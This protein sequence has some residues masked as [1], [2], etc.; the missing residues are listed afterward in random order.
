MNSYVLNGFFF[1]Y[2]M[3]I[4]FACMAA[5]ALS[6][7]SW[8]VSHKRACLPQTG[9]FVC[10][11]IELGF[12]FLNE[13]LSQN[14]T[15][16]IEEYY[17]IEVPA[18]RVL[19]SG[20]MV[21]C[22]WLMLLDI[23][24][25]HDRRVQVLPVVAFVL[26]SVAI[27]VLMPYGK[28]RQWA[29]YSMRQ[30]FMACSMGFALYKYS[31]A[32]TPAYHDRLFKMRPEFLMICLFVIAIFVEDTIVILVLPPVVNVSSLRLYVSERNFC[33]NFLVLYVAWFVCRESLSTLRLRASMPPAGKE[34]DLERHIVDAL[35]TYGHAHS[36]SLRE[37][38][39]LKLV[40]EGKD[41]NA[42]AQS[43]VLSVGTVKTHVHNIMQKTGTSTRDE[44]KNNFW[45]S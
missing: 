6:I 36:L 44:L 11:F 37:Q 23:L 9:F 35:P 32:K 22:L 16:P 18:F 21:A 41:N 28:E 39:V 10:Y 29:F 25:E 12:I 24:D 13:W 20:A 5:A 14:T 27:L 19:I 34:T 42:I 40:L 33:E 43:L 30:L 45:S 15:F 26:A 2:T 4:L 8:Y 1:V 17:I 31:R 7:A 3:F 38:E